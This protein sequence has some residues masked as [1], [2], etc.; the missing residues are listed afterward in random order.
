M[1]P[2]GVLG[3]GRR[4]S[5]PGEGGKGHKG[6]GHVPKSKRQRVDDANSE[7]DDDFQSEEVAVVDA[8]GTT[9]VKR[10]G[11][12]RD[13]VSR[14]QPAALK[15]TAVGGAA[16]VSPR[17]PKAPG[18]VITEARMQRQVAGG[19]GRRGDGSGRA[20]AATSGTPPATGGA[21]GA[22]R[23][24]FAQKG[25]AT[26]PDSR[27]AAGDHHTTGSG[28][29]EGAEEGRVDDVSRHDGRRGGRREGDDEDDHPLISRWKRTPEEDA[30]EERSKLW[31]DCNAF[32]GQGP[33]KPLREAVGDCED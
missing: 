1:A 32:W 31:V 9:G 20:G 22:T 28:V 15:Q 25:E 23:I 16:V 12:G 26:V 4:D 6:R 14:E 11:F 7:N 21:S 18:I 30:L 3:K 29:A 24:P 33:R 2:Q 27:T 10:L 19:R 13:G 17:T 5:R 8:Q